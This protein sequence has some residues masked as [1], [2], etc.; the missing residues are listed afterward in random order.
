[1][2]TFRKSGSTV[3]IEKIQHFKLKVHH[4]NWKR[5]KKVLS[6][7]EGGGGG[8]WIRQRKWLGSGESKVA[9]GI[10]CTGSQANRSM[11][12]N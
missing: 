6:C 3:K 10:N 7:R 9:K 1:M 12:L 8:G 2:E 11:K 4:Q 5:K